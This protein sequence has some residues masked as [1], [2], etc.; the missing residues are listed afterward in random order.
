MWWEINA[1]AT[2]EVGVRIVTD[3]RE[4][5]QSEDQDNK[6]LAT[7]RIFWEHGEISEGLRHDQAE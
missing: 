1:M 4:D 7:P 5:T 3:Q 6:T 2:Y